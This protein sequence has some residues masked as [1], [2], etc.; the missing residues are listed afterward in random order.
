MRYSFTG[1]LMKRFFF[2]C[3][4]NIIMYLLHCL[5]LLILALLC[6]DI[7][8]QY[9]DLC[10]IGTILCQIMHAR[11]NELRESVKCC[12]NKQG[13]TLTLNTIAH[14]PMSARVKLKVPTM[15]LMPISDDLM[16]KDAKVIQLLKQFCSFSG[17][18]F[19][20]A[21]TCLTAQLGQGEGSDESGVEVAVAVPLA[22]SDDEPATGRDAEAAQTAADKRNYQV[23][24]LP[25]SFFLKPYDNAIWPILC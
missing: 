13:R 11:G 23:W 8:K 10:G 4:L 1:K 6:N 24:P 16:I 2:H 21:I 3:P 15:L 19:V 5:C 9:S 12:L 14:S 20:F 25:T 18:S 22:E 7:C 17:L